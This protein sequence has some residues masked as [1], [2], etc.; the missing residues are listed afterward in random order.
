LSRINA[1]SADDV[2]PIA[3]RGERRDRQQLPG[4]SL[5]SQFYSGEPVL[6]PS[7]VLAEFGIS[8]TIAASP[9]DSR[10]F[11][12]HLSATFPVVVSQRRPLEG[13]RS[14][15]RQRYP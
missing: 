5:V 15:I 9:E 1:I 4:V 14:S 6:K 10:S 3:L 8:V 12:K 13:A 11:T 2:V 7:S